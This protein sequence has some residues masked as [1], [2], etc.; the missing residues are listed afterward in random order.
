[1]WERDLLRYSPCSSSKSRERLK[2]QSCI[3][4]LQIQEHRSSEP[5]TVLRRDAILFV[6]KPFRSC[7]VS[8]SSRMPRIAFRGLSLS[9]ARSL[10]SN[11]TKRAK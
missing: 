5:S 9:L 8:T 2:G 11:L 7:R 6:I 3:F 1:M 10:I 4:Q